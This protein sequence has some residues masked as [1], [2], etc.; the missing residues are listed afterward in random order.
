MEDKVIIM[1][2][3]DRRDTDYGAAGGGVG[4]DA[5]A[6]S[7][8]LPRKAGASAPAVVAKPAVHGARSR[9]GVRDRL[10]G[11][12]QASSHRVGGGRRAGGARLGEPD[13]VV[14]SRLAERD[15][16]VLALVA[17]H[18]VLTTWQL[19]ALVFPSAARAQRRLREL[20][21]LGMLFRTQ[22]HRAQ[23]G[24]AP[25]HYLLAYRGAQLLAAQ[26]GA[27]S[28]RPAAHAERI[29]RTLESPTLRHLLGVNQF[30]ADLAGYGRGLGKDRNALP[31]GEGLVSWHSETW[32]RKY[33][34]PPIRPD[35]YGLWTQH[36]TSLGFF[37]EY[38]TGTE[39]L[40]RVADKLDDY[41]GRYLDTARQLTGMVLFWV[42]THR[43]EQGLRK[44]LEAKHCP[45][46]IA[47]A[48]RDH[49]HPD[50]PAGE[51][52]SVL[53]TEAHSHRRVRLAD[54]APVIGGT[55]P[56]GTPTVLPRLPEPSDQDRYGQEYWYNADDHDD[57]DDD[58][59]PQELPSAPSQSEQST[60]RRRSWFT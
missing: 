41:T 55:E 58:H 13:G 45:V 28:P 54:L 10:T 29:V 53:T 60:L 26:C 27:S 20:A 31:E 4:R 1:M 36:G 37:L 8:V 9:S 18:Q 23:G 11:N 12:S 3:T 43:R 16:T 15:R 38:D 32:I 30:F 7:R 44:A 33:Y 6:V 24:S 14:W 46:P 57:S 48:S 35:G 51:I 49:D 52:W 42:A 5:G 50:G 17:E 39:P 59:Q 47:T 21:D 56:D 19:L 40:G 22:P 25:F 34:R 2:D